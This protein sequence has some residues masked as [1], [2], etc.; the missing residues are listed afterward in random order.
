M[1]QTLVEMAKDLVLAQI[2]AHRLSPE[3]MPQA[4]QRTHSILLELQAQEETDGSVTSKD[5][6]TPKTRPAWS[7][8][9]LLLWYY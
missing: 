9:A 4:L 2:E 7:R 5:P 8:Q 6:E 1:A 3:E